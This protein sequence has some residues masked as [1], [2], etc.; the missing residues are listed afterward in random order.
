MKTKHLILII[1]TFVFISCY[2][3][4]KRINISGVVTDAS[5]NSPIVGA[6]IYFFEG[7]GFGRYVKRETLTDQNGNYTLE[8]HGECPS[9]LFGRWYVSAM[10]EG[11]HSKDI[12][13]ACSSSSYIINIE[14]NPIDNAIVTVQQ[15]SD[16]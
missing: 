1:I 12:D 8:Y 13:I 15:N 3:N 7:T 5:T 10:K 9:W 6:W 14:L 2:S 11:Y 4:V 16:R